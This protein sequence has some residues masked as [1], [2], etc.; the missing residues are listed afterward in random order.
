MDARENYCLNIIDFSSLD[1]ISASSRADVNA[2]MN[3]SIIADIP[4]PD[5]NL[6]ILPNRPN[7]FQNTT[8]YIT[9]PFTNNTTSRFFSHIF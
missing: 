8:N 9:L 6:P 2:R 5:T 3:K 7:F 4:P 1:I